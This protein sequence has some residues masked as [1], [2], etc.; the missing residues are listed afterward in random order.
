MADCA[1]EMKAPGDQDLG[2]E[3]AGPCQCGFNVGLVMHCRVCHSTPG[4]GSGGGV[5]VL[6]VVANVLDGLAPF[7]VLSTFM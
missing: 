7:F 4:G 2:A 3:F 5:L 1:D 6:L